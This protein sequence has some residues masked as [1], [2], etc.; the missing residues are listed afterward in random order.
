MYFIN[1]AHRDFVLVIIESLQ[2]KINWV[3]VNVTHSSPH[4]VSSHLKKCGTLSNNE[5][6]FVAFSALAWDVQVNAQDT[7]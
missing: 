5:V 6:I 4:D 3:I 7:C 1:A 2:S